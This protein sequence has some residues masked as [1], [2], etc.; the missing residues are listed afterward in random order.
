[1]WQTY[2]IVHTL[3]DALKILAEYKESARIINGGT[4][5]LLEMQR[6][7]RHGVNHLIDLSHPSSLKYIYKD[8]HEVIHIGPTVTH[9]EVI[10]SHLLRNEAPPLA[11]ACL[12]VGSPQIRNRGTVSGNLVTASPANDTI[13]A[14]MA[15]GA[16]LKLR[17]ISSERTLPIDEFF[18]GLRKTALAADEMLVDIAFPSMSLNKINLASVAKQNPFSDTAKGG[19]FKLGLRKAHAISV[20]N[21]AFVL[22]FEQNKV[23][24]ATITLGSVAPTVIHAKRAEEWLIG[25]T[26]TE[27]SIQEAAEIA[28]SAARPIDDLRATAAYRHATVRVCVARGLMELIKPAS[29][30]HL[31]FESTPLLNNSIPQVQTTI[32]N[33]ITKFTSIENNTWDKP[34]ITNINGKEYTF[35]SGHHKTLLDLIRD[36][37]HLSGTKN[38]CGEGECGA[39]TVILDGKAVMGCLVPAPRAHAANILTVEGLA[40]GENLHP[41]Q[42]A[43]IDEGAV[44]CGYCTPGFLMA[45]YTLLEEIP[46]PSKEQIRHSLSGNICRCTGYYKIIQAIE[47]AAQSMVS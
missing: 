8:A 46:Q 36:E 35:T 38:G 32:N 5:L 29:D 12:Q 18:L 43:F 20:V 40:K 42:Q 9:N 30:Y 11:Q 31:P 37:A 25:K 28:A 6:G 22:Y 10:A 2:S 39:C 24:K 27:E 17:S 19:F 47:H 33:D 3:Q 21:A 34:I 7:Q 23:S 41:L 16:I 26:L 14:L 44:Q 45:A 15:L 4:D 1:M 13:A